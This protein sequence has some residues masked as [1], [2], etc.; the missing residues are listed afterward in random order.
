MIGDCTDLRSERPS[1]FE[2]QCATYSTYKGCSTYKALIG[3]SPSGV[4][5]FI[6]PLHEGSIS[7]NDITN[8][9]DLRDLLEP[10]D[11]MMADRGWTC[12]N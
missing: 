10:G 9:T 3:I 4:P 8:K 7:D 12:A 2:V 6:S 1:D 11:H 5:T